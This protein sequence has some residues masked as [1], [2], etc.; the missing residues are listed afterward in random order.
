MPVAARYSIEHFGPDPLDRRRSLALQHYDDHGDD[1]ATRRT[2]WLSRWGGGGNVHAAAIRRVDAS[3]F[4]RR[5]ELREHRHRSGY[6]DGVR[7]IGG[8][9]VRQ[10]A[11]VSASE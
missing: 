6:R 11:S 10:I 7:R 2:G 8:G 3:A 5:A 4:G 9:G 1:C